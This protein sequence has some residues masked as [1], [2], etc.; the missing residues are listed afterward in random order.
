MNAMQAAL[1]DGIYFRHGERPPAFFM[2]LLLAQADKADPA[3]VN[4]QLAKLWEVYAGLKE[5][6]VRDLPGFRVPDGNLGVLLGFGSNAKL[7]PEFEM[8]DAL[9]PPYAFAPMKPG[10][11]I[12]GGPED[13]GICYAKQA[14]DLAD[15]AFAVQFTADTPLAVERAI[16]ETWKLLHDEGEDAALEIVAVFSG[17]QRDDGRS[18]ID[19][20]D[21]L[22]N[23]KPTERAEAIVIGAGSGP[24]PAEWTINGSYLA[25]IRLR[26]NLAIWRDLNDAQQGRLVGRDKLTGCP[27]VSFGDDEDEPGVPAVGCPIPGTL[28]AE[29]ENPFAIR[30][31]S[32]TPPRPSPPRP[33]CGGPTNGTRAATSPFLQAR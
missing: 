9:P 5:G 18:W 23:L 11:P 27:L 17:S 30:R 4:E 33:T 26:I 2:L 1:Q 24:R 12:V 32:P 22:S 8:S 31:R 19:F 7:R 29:G 10:N 6:R 20:H 15:V 21:G 14:A 13:G 25:F 16:V 28:T 3:S